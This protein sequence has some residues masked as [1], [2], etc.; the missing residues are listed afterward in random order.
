[1]PRT[2]TYCPEEIVGDCN[3]MKA[4]WEQV[5]HDLSNKTHLLIA[6]ATC[7]ALVDHIDAKVDNLESLHGGPI[8]PAGTDPGYFLE[9][10]H[11]AVSAFGNLTEKVLAGKYEE[12]DVYTA[13]ARFSKIKD[14]FPNYEVPYGP[15]VQERS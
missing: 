12:R 5:R 15:F 8:W 1:M 2:R 7:R 10:V 11:Q 9:K 4:I 13:F 14:A 6:Y 3:V